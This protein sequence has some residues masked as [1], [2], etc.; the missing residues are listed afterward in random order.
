M[1]VARPR[2]WIGVTLAAAGLALVAGPGWSTPTDPRGDPRR[3][4]LVWQSAG[5][6]TCHRFARA[7]ST[8]K[9]GPNID[10]WLIPHSRR[11]KMPVDRF[12]LS[13]VT[14]GGRGMPAYKVELTAEEVDDVVSFVIGRP[15]A[16]PAAGVGP[17]PFFVVPPLVTAGPRVVARWVTLEGLRGTAIRGAQI[18]AREGC[19]SCHTYHGSGVRRHG[20]RD[21]TNG[22]A[23]RWTAAS[24]RRYVSRPYLHGNNLMPMYA[25]L[26]VANLSA[27]ADFLIASRGRG[28]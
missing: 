10:R 27:V 2:I 17:A 13:R 28:R 18:F 25:D 7:G 20:A 6:G 26:G 3:G 1:R 24:L 5:C 23:K 15:F 8:G 21:L 22:S 9:T 19:L 14:W 11:A 16:A 12:V 4:Q